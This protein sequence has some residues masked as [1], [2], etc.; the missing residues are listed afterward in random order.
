MSFDESV[1][2]FLD[3]LQ[4]EKQDKENGEKNFDSPLYKK[5]FRSK[6]QSGFLSIRPWLTKSPKAS[7]IFAS[8]SKLIVV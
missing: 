7:K 3:E 8:Y 6:T 2:S 5:W 4:V 1:E